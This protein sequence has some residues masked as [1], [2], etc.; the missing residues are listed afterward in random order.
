MTHTG[1]AKTAAAEVA[2]ALTINTVVGAYTG[3][4]AAVAVAGPGGSKAGLDPSALEDPG[5]DEALLLV[6]CVCGWS[7]DM[8]ARVCALMSRRVPR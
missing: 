1:G 7:N 3:V 5:H 6:S 8:R 2:A 4:V